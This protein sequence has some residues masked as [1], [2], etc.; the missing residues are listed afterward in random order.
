MANKRGSI[1]AISTGFI[2]AFTLLGF[3]A[4]YFAGTQSQEIEKKVASSKAF[5]LAEAGIEKTLWEFNI[6][7]STWP[8]WSI[9]NGTRV[10]QGNLTTFSG[11]ET[12]GDYDVNIS[13]YNAN[14]PVIRATGYV[15][16]RTGQYFK[17]TVHVNI[18]DNLFFKYALFAN[19]TVQI[20]GNLTTDS[21]DSSNGTYGGNNTGDEGNVGANGDVD[22]SGASYNVNGTITENAAELL[23]TVVIPNQLISLPSGGTMSEGSLNAG[24]YKF[25]GIDL[26]GTDTLTITGPANIY[27]TP[28]STDSIDM[29]SSPNVEIRIS[30]S[31]TGPIKIYADGDVRITGG[32][33]INEA[34]IPENFFIYGTGGSGQE[35][36][37]SGT[38]S[39]YGIIYAPNADIKLSG[40]FTAFG[41]IIGQNITTDGTVFVHYDEALGQQTGEERYTVLNWQEVD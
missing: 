15:P 34:G 10:F 13:A 31:S 11:N 25:T 16:A 19:D 9:I 17:R 27:L 41:A 18:R 30:N 5:W 2:L 12:I 37:A 38:D 1:L 29:T 20:N 26:S 14:F 3:G 24:N 23:S 32:G 40:N 7:T 22:V 4:V 21:Y 6:N 39:F 35:I 33:V 28:N 8:D 36:V